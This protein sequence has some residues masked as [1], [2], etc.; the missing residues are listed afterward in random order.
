MDWWRADSGKLP[1][2]LR[3][4]EVAKSLCIP[5]KGLDAAGDSLKQS[6]LI[7]AKLKK[8]KACSVPLK[9]S[10]IVLEVGVSKMCHDVISNMLFHCTASHCVFVCFTGSLSF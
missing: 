4:K 8:F 5:L 1:R 2:V 6:K 9:V 10:G 3:T 7:N